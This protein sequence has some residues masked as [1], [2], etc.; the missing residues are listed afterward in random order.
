[1]CA[2]CKIGGCRLQAYYTMPL[3]PD[4]NN[5]GFRV[6]K[7]PT[8]LSGREVKCWKQSLLVGINNLRDKQYQ[9]GRNDLVKEVRA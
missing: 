8:R 5:Q 1:M 4:V 9:L 2:S 3:I 7:F 6:V